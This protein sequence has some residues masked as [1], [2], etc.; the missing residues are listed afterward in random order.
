MLVCG[1]SLR[2]KR[3]IVDI[4][5]EDSRAYLR[6]DLYSW[7]F[8]EFSDG[9]ISHIHFTIAMPT[10][11]L[12][13]LEF[14]M[15]YKKYFCT[16]WI[17]DE[18]RASDMSFE[19]FLHECE[20]SVFFCPWDNSFQSC[21]IFIESFS[22]I[23]EAWDELEYLHEQANYSTIL[24]MNVIESTPSEKLNPEARYEAASILFESF[25]GNDAFTDYSLEW[26]NPKDKIDIIRSFYERI[27]VFFDAIGGLRATRDSSGE[28]NSVGT[29]I[30]HNID[31]W[32]IHEA[33]KHAK[34][35]QLALMGLI[36]NKSLKNIP[37]KIRALKRFGHL[38]Q[39]T[40]RMRVADMERKPHVYAQYL[41]ANERNWAGLRLLLRSLKYIKNQWVPIYFWTVS[42]ANQKM[43]SKLWFRALWEIKDKTSGLSF[44]R[45]LFD[46]NKP[47]TQDVQGWTRTALNRALASE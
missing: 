10:K 37:E 7:L 20:F 43:Y 3:N 41:W 19:I 42:H 11:L 33:E 34:I 47:T 14:L 45:F 12:P 29:F 24:L 38:V 40:D 35:N 16:F 18:H 17:C 21:T 39:F 5:M 6:F 28:I 30:P 1:P 15:K 46:P 31:S 13:S 23:S 9:Y 25:K 26:I 27:T 36:Y 44:W 4:D 8:M 32:S 2:V 22:V